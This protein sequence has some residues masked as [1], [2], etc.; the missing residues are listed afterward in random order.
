MTAKIT[1]VP[2]L[3]GLTEID[4]IVPK[5]M[6]NFIP[7]WWKNTPYKGGFN[8]LDSSYEGNIKTCPSFI[9]YFRFGYVV[10]SWCDA[11]LAYDQETQIW[12]ARSSHGAFY[13]GGEDPAQTVNVMPYSLQGNKALFTFKARSPWKIMTDPGYSVMVLPLFF[14]FNNDFSVV[15]G[16]IDTDIH[17]TFGPDIMYHSD[18]KEIKIKRGEPL[19]HLFPF[20]R[21]E[22]SLDVIEAYDLDNERYKRLT[23][24]D[25][26]LGTLFKGDKAYINLRKKNNLEP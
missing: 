15:P 13:F 18:K 1:F 19:Y 10:P 22:T 9:D 6:R 3:P 14:N 2:E 5:P 8:T 20:K 24:S 23:T 11:I 7:D 21:E 26:E 17:H 16:I 12:N 4:E 25:A